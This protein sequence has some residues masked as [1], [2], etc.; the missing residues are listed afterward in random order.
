[1]VTRKKEF[2]RFGF[3]STPACGSKVKAFGPVLFWHPFDFAQGR[4]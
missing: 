3:A 4:L 2:G 1:M